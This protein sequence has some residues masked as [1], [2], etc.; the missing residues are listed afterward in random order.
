M[1]LNRVRQVG[2]NT[3][4]FGVVGNPIYHSK[5]PI[6]FNTAFVAC[7][8]DAVFVPFLVENLKDFLSGY[9][10]PDFAGFRCDPLFIPFLSFPYLISW[11]V[12]LVYCIVFQILFI[13]RRLFIWISNCK[14]HFPLCKLVW[15]QFLQPRCHK[16]FVSIFAV[17]FCVPQVIHDLRY[18]HLKP[19]VCTVPIHLGGFK[20]RW[21]VHRIAL[22][23]CVG[24]RYTYLRFVCNLRGCTRHSDKK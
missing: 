3:K 24:S 14:R 8:I 15:F 17:G 22:R 11:Y 20:C 10:S 23:L 19:T 2:Q 18:I 6:I 4:V 1:F 13:N 9:G 21:V 5:S 7:G 16:V 12:D